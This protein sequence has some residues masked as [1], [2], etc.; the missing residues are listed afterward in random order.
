MLPSN[1]AV[2]LKQGCYVA[3]K[4]HIVSGIQSTKDN[5]AVYKANTDMKLLRDYLR[6]RASSAICTVLLQGLFRRLRGLHSSETKEGIFLEFGYLNFKR[7][8]V[9][10]VLVS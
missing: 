1:E 6:L 3:A 2:M 10:N 7:N 5:A 8:S 4:R 9:R